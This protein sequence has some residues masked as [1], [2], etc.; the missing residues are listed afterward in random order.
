MV[1]VVQTGFLIEI[2]SRE[3]EWVLNLFLDEDGFSEG[4][5]CGMPHDSSIPVQQPV[6]GTEVVVQE[7]VDPGP[8]TIDLHGD[9]LSVPV[10]DIPDGIAI[11]S[12]LSNQVP[13]E[14]VMIVCR[15]PWAT[16]LTLRPMPS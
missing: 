7:V 10:E 13:L 6:G 8:E 15:A 11:G 9:P 12:G 14:V 5:V 16:L 2:L 1:V 4:K 3:S